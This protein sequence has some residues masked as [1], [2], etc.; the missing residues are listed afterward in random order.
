[1]LTEAGILL[2]EARFKILSVFLQ[3]APQVIFTCFAGRE[4][5]MKILIPYIKKLPV[6]EVHIWDYTRSESDAKYLREACSEFTLFSVTDKSNYG[7]Y[8][9]YYTRQKFPD[10]YTVI[11][12]CDDDIVFID[13]SAFSD[14]IRARRMFPEVLVMSPT[15]VNNPVCEVVQYDRGITPTPVEGFFAVHAPCKEIHD[16]FLHNPKKYISDCKQKDRLHYIPH[17]QV[18]YRFNINFIA[19]LAKDLDILFHNENV[20][21]DDELFLGGVASMFYKRNILID[22]HFVVC[23]M[24]YTSQRERGYDETQHLEEYSK[25]LENP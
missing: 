6:D 10:P 16:H 8:Y 1:M 3:M 14:F 25:I 12:K 23:H 19:V 24:A 18:K 7:E 9:S 2:R 17:E 21:K 11:I 22:L 5:Y 20:M 4:R 15:V 13:T